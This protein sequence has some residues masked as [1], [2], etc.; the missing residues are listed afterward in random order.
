M[1]HFLIDPLRVLVFF[2]HVS[3][4]QL[5]VVVSKDA[6]VLFR[7]IPIDYTPKLVDVKHL[8]LP[9]L[10]V[11]YDEHRK[12]SRTYQ[13]ALVPVEDWLDGQVVFLSLLP[14]VEDAVADASEVAVMQVLEALPVCV[15]PAQQINGLGDHFN[16]ELG[17]TALQIAHCLTEVRVE[18]SKRV[19]L[20][21]DSVPEPLDRHL[22][23][24]L[25]FVDA[26]EVM[27]AANSLRLNPQR[28]IEA[29]DCT[30]PVPLGEVLVAFEVPELPRIEVEA[31]LLIDNNSL[32]TEPYLV[33]ALIL[34]ELREWLDNII[35]RVSLQFA[36]D[37][38]SNGQLFDDLNRLTL[39]HYLPNKDGLADVEHL[40][41]CASRQV[42]GRS[43]HLFL[44][45]SIRVLYIDVRRL[46]LCEHL[47]Q[48]RTV[49]RRPTVHS[50]CRLRRLCRRSSP[51]FQAWCH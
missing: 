38:L 34:L 27:K 44:E 4:S 30:F 9:V 2:Q 18:D 37:F 6:A 35:V 5:S 31:L 48:L 23:A 32:R 46:R 29:I 11:R 49:K 51:L 17:L 42:D 36:E 16:R 15:D 43:D 19:R 33:D 47:R 40:R 7:L 24:L 22:E 41:A 8:V 3:L 14:H 12:D 1:I 21:G 26:S 10:L 39:L 20:D 28:L 45:F 50:E 13:L 25:L